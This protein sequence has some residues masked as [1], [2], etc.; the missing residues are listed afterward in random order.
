MFFWCLTDSLLVTVEVESPIA[1]STFMQVFEG[2]KPILVL[3]T[4]STQP[5]LLVVPCSSRYMPETLDDIQKFG[6]HSSTVDTQSPILCM[7]S[8]PHLALLAT[9]VESEFR[10]WKVNEGK[11]DLVSYKIL[12]LQIR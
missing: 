12:L 11:F 10:V 1:M 6:A 2:S 3:L 7:T 4:Y 8:H 5:L 9:S